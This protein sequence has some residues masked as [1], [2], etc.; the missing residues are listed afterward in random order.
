MVWLT[1]EY[2][3]ATKHMR[4]E[5][6]RRAHLV[7]EARKQPKQAPQSRNGRA[8][9]WRIE[10]GMEDAFRD[11]LGWMLPSQR[12]APIETAASPPHSSA[13]AQHEGSPDSARQSLAA[14]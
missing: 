4:E 13:S 14:R 7:S 9:R 2:V 1:D 3:N 12:D 5:E 6:I 10:P 11:L 8:W